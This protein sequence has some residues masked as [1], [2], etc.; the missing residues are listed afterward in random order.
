MQEKVAKND[1][2]T[3]PLRLLHDVLSPD[4]SQSR[5]PG[6]HSNLPPDHQVVPVQSLTEDGEGRRGTDSFFLL[7]FSCTETYSY[8]KYLSKSTAANA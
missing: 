1:F 3:V 4:S 2:R 8:S 7:I 6:N 5:P